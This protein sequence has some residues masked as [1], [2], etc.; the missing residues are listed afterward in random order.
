MKRMMT[1]LLTLLL[2][3][4]LCATVSAEE[5]KGFD[6]VLSTVERAEG[7][8]IAAGEEFAIEVSLTAIDKL[9]MVEYHF[10]YDKTLMEPVSAS[11]EGFLLD[12]VMQSVNT[13]PARNDAESDTY[14]E[15]WITGMADSDKSVAEGEVISTIVFK[16]KTD[17]TADSPMVG[18]YADGCDA[19]FSNYECGMVSGGI[20]IGEADTQDIPAEMTAPIN[21]TVPKDN[22]AVTPVS[23]SDNDNDGPVMLIAV[24]VIGVLAAGVLVVLLVMAKKK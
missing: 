8:K 14:G 21:N 2:M 23:D 6:Y 10:R 1:A 4:S 7:E 16:A 24:I 15:V 11:S 20:V 19:A 22:G 13:E 17:I 3:M 18:Y 9:S 5:A 12:C